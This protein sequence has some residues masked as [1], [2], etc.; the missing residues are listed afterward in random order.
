MITEIIK[1]VIAVLVISAAIAS[2]FIESAVAQT[3][4]VPLAAFA[5]GYY[6][7]Q[8]EAPVVLRAKVALG[9]K[10]TQTE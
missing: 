7:K 4:L 5:F 1:G 2:V 3:F 6:F 9:K 8:V 10:Q